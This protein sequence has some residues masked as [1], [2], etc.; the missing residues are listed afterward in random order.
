[1]SPPKVSVH[2]AVGVVGVVG[3]LDVLVGLESIGLAVGEEVGL[4]VGLDGGIIA[5]V[6]VPVGDAKRRTNT[7]NVAPKLVSAASRR[8]RRV[9][10]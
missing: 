9:M 3:V 8:W 4:D 10:L 5:E 2:G 1:V 6:A 7:I